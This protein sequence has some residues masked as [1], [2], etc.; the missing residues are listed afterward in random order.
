MLSPWSCKESD[1]TYCITTIKLC[2]RRMASG[3]AFGGLL[4][5]TTMSLMPAVCQTPTHCPDRMD[6]FRQKGGM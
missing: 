2:E 4:A 6:C 5:N 1:I 3:L